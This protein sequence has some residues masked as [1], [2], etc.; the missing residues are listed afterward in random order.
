MHM[1]FLILHCA[2]RPTTVGGPSKREQE[3]LFPSLFYRMLSF[4]IVEAH[5][6]AVSASLSLFF[7]AAVSGADIVRAQ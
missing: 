5:R 2:P 6:G 3:V 7:I 4:V 1:V